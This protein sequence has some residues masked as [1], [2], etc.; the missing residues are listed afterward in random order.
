MPTPSPDFWRLLDE[1]VRAC[2]L[3]ID[4]PQGTPHPRY[5]DLIY[6][7]DY[8]YLEGTRSGDEGGIDVW[9]GSALEKT[10]TAV[11]CTVD[12]HKRDAEV[13]ILLGCT[14]VEA[15]TVLAF[16]NSGSQAAVLIERRANDRFA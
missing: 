12:L 16:H 2:R 15:Q 13:K 10:V 3:K 14:P 9:V 5:P 1:L 8:G 4:R 11:I 7:L 6:P